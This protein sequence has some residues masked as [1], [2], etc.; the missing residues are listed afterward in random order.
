[1]TLV[2]ARWAGSNSSIEDP[3]AVGVLTVDHEQRHP[4]GR[5]LDQ[6]TQH[7]DVRDGQLADPLAGQLLRPGGQAVTEQHGFLIRAAPGSGHRADEH[8]AELF[9]VHVFHPAFV[10]SQADGAQR[11][12]ITNVPRRKNCEE[13]REAV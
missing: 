8:R 3:A 4:L 7:L 2:A 11:R 5:Q 1:M 10:G 12:P 6:R 13:A 9:V